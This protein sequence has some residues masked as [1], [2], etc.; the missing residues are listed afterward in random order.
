MNIFNSLGSNY[1]FKKAVEALTIPN[2]K[3][4][5]EELK[6]IL[7]EKYGGKAYLTYKGREAIN[8][9]FSL[10]ESRRKK[11]A[12]NGFTCFVV[13]EPIEKAGYSVKLIDIER[14]DL[15][16]TSDSLENLARKENLAAVVIQNT[17]GY[18]CDIVKIQKICKEN[19]ILLIE[20]L[21]HSVGAHYSNG[22]EAG[23]VGD[24]VIL[25]FSQDKMIDAISGGALVVRNKKYVKD[26]SYK[27]NQKDK[28]RDR[29]YPLLTVL[30]RTLYP[31]II[32]KWLH[33]LLKRMN[34]LSAPMDGLFSPTTPLSWEC[35]FAIEE[36]KTLKENISHRQQIAKIYQGNLASSLLRKNTEN[37]SSSSSLRFPIFVNNRK[38]LIEYL[39]KEGVYVSDIWYDAPIAPHRFLN[40]TTYN[41][42]CPNAE[43]VSQTILNLPT[44][45]N[46]SI[47]DANKLVESINQWEKFQ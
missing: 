15:N 10:I 36:F 39:R 7:E 46:V 43:V 34:A 18:P 26:V 13:Y 27:R 33:F 25:S 41:G 5:N 32:G 12:V 1:T 21:A 35:K 44:H 16:F 2:S 29:V 24:F 17:L 19:N 11:V 6:E 40:R 3:K 14:D 9:A 8:L 42:E 45:K 37:I 23:T 4:H 28:L 30:I 38:G 47:E 31:F 20:D 22:T